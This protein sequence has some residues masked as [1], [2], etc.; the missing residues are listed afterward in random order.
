MVQPLPVFCSTSVLGF[1]ALLFDCPTAMQFLGLRQ[2]IPLNSLPASFDAFGLG[3]T[4]Q[5]PP[6]SSSIKVR[7][8]GPTVLRPS[9]M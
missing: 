2:V 6:V 1:D 7:V 3:T 9:A 8:S 4:F 5:P